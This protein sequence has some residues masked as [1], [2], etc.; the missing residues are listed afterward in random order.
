M[1]NTDWLRPG[2][3]YT[4]EQGIQRHEPGGMEAFVRNE[5]LLA[6]VPDAYI[7]V[8]IGLHPPV[9]WMEANRMN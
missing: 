6:E 8:R 3:D 9:D 7:I 2:R 4:D 1:T 5:M